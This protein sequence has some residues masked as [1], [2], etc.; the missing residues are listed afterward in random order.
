[1]TLQRAYKTC[2]KILVVKLMK[3]G[4]HVLF[5]ISDVYGLSG[6]RVQTLIPENRGLMIAKCRR[7][8]MPGKY[9]KNRGHFHICISGC[10]ITL[11]RT[12]LLVNAKRAGKWILYGAQILYLV[13]CDELF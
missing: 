4:I 7:T 3:L 5:S 1:V 13:K 12:Q 10:S 6:F 11:G 9:G 8:F 2:A